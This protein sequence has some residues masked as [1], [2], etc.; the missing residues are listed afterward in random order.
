M[1]VVTKSNLIV[2]RFQRGQHLI[3]G[4][5]ICMTYVGNF[6]LATV[7]LDDPVMRPTQSIIVPTRCIC[8]SLSLR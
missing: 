3:H 8:T 1:V 5:R 6:A 7:Y 4:S 2:Q